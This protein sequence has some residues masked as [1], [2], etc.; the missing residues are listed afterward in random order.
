MP[1]GRAAGAALELARR[2]HRELEEPLLSLL[3]VPARLA[4][5]PAVLGAEDHER[6]H[7]QALLAIADRLERRCEARAQALRL[8]RELVD[9]HARRL[10]RHQRDAGLSRWHAARLREPGPR[11]G[12]V[13]ALREAG[14]ELAGLAVGRAILDARAP[15]AEVAHDQPQRAADRQVGAVAL[16]EAVA[17]RVHP[18]LLG[19]RSGD[20]DQRAGGIRGRHK[21]VE[22]E[23]LVARRLHRRQHDRQRLGF[24][25]RHD[26]VDRDLL[27]RRLA[28]V[29]RELADDLLRVAARVLEHRHDPLRRRRHDRQPVGHAAVEER[30]DRVL[31]LADGQRARRGCGRRRAL[32]GRRGAPRPRGRGSRSRS[33]AGARAGRRGRASRPP[34]APAA[35]AAGAA[36]PRPARAPRRRRAG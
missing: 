15:A 10:R 30:L 20:D 36:G 23:P 35:P 28:A 33:P 2:R 3:A 8:A 21:A 27:D 34:R 11:R 32:A 19:E 14:R 5:E 22:R 6:V 7:G 13:E 1:L 24:A 18:G 9:D 16:P 12:L 17:R 4:E 29:G 25:A 26:R 31:E